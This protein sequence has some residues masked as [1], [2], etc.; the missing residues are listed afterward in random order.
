[1]PAGPL[2]CSQTTQGA[3]RALLASHPNLAERL[4]DDE[5]RRLPDAAQNNNTGAVRLML[6]AGWPVDATGEYQMTPLHWAAWHGNAEMVQEFCGT[7]PSSKRAA[8]IESRY[9]GPRSTVRKTV[10]TGKRATTPLQWRLC[11]KRVPER[12]SSPTIWKPARRRE[13]LRRYEERAIQ[14]ATF[15]PEESNMG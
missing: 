9:W 5:R 6:A 12:Q 8:S 7:L 1:M 10:G 15:K 2:G 3:F 13:V 4:S 11:W 14:E